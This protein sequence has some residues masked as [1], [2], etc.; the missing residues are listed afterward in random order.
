M[1][2]QDFLTQVNDN[3]RGTDDVAPTIGTDDANYWLRVANH[4]RRTVYNDTS[5]QWVSTY[6]VLPLGTISVSG[7]PSFPLPAGFL[8]AAESCYALDV[9]GARS[10]FPI[11][12]PQEQDSTTQAV[13]V[14]GANP[15]TLYFTKAITAQ[16]GYVGDT[17]YLP[18][19]VMPTDIVG[20]TGT[21]TVVVDD[22]DW[23]AM[24]TAAELAFNDITYESKAVDLNA[25]ANALYKAMLSTNRRGTST[26]PRKS[27]YNVARIGE[28]HGARNL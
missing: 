11:I 8:D 9:S 28:R 23:L 1:T 5:K 4:I 16:E 15:Q 12:K 14:A 6:Q 25:K 18:A 13:F 17:L 20:T 10:D 26:N 2:T 27:R 3:W 21:E 7:A 22:P 19:Y 24:A